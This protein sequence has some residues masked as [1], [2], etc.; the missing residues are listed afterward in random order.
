[1]TPDELAAVRENRLPWR[2]AAELTR[3][4]EGEGRAS[5]LAQA[6]AEDLSTAQVGRLARELQGADAFTTRARQLVAELK[7]ARLAALPA[8]QREKAEALLTELAALL[9]T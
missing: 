1:M 9:H 4:P 8:A 7:P 5:L 3:L 6:I 2:T